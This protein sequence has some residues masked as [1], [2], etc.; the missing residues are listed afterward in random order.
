MRNT[1]TCFITFD[2]VKTYGPY[3]VRDALMKIDS[4]SQTDSPQLDSS[5]LR[6]WNL[7]WRKPQPLDL[8]KPYLL[9]DLRKSKFAS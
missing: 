9:Q 3:T 4:F 8:A 1:P 7:G 5:L 6:V 2:T